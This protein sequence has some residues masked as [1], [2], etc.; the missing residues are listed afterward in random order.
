MLAALVLSPVPARLLIVADPPATVDAAVVMAGDPDY[1]RTATAARLV[2]EGKARLLVVT[3]GEP[4]PGDS[5]G[6]LE[7]KARE[8]GVPAHSIRRETASHSTR[9]AMLAVRP[10]LAAEGVRSVALVTSP[11]H[12][13]RAY[14]AARRAWPGIAIRNQPADPSSFR[15]ERWWRGSR[16]R[17]AVLGEYAKLVYYLARGWLAP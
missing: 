15:P 3:G 5:A 9:E 17:R 7:A 11:Y 4:G 6:S 10:I 12:Q 2:R 14:H 1:E 16:S 8:W 13:R